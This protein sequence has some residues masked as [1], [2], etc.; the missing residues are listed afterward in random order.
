MYVYICIYIYIFECVVQDLG[1]LVEC[2]PLRHIL[3]HHKAI[4]TD[5]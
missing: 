4:L 3:E 5:I 2:I 1:F